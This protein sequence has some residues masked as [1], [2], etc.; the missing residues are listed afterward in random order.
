MSLKVDLK[1][2]LKGFTL[3]ISFEVQN[4]VAVLFGPSGSGKSMTLNSIAGLFNPD[5]GRISL[6][7]KIFFEEGNKQL[8]PQKRRLGYIFQNHSLFPHMT[9]EENILFGGREIEKEKRQEKCY[10][11][12]KKFN[13]NDLAKKMPREISGGQAQRVALARALIGEPEA[14]LLDEPFSA[15]DTPTR[16]SIGQ[17]L[18]DVFR[19]LSI[20]V[21]FVTHDIYEAC[22]MADKMIILHDGEILQV[23]TPQEVYQHPL[24]ELVHKLV[25]LDRHLEFRR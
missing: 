7:E 3:N 13:L 19:E 12:L 15:L 20:P 11:F 23:G 21:I 1:K 5:R 25:R 24:N 6:G 9:V 10:E 22:A 4:E 14:L 2:N 16:V 8:P 17:C 18:S